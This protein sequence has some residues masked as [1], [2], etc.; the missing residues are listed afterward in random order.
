MSGVCTVRVELEL[1]G[2]WVEVSADVVAGLRWTRGL[3]GTS[4]RDRVAGTGLCE[5]ALRNDARNAGGTAGW[6]SPNHASVRTGF[7][8]G[9]AV[10]VI[11]NDGSDRPQWYGRL[12][13][14]LPDAGQFGTRQTHC[15]AQDYMGDLAEAQVRTMPAQV[16]KTEVE[17]LQAILAALPAELQPA[18]TSYDTALDSYPYA[19]YDTGGGAN[20]MDLANRVVTSTQGYLYV[21]N[22][23][24]LRYDNRHTVALRSSS[25]TFTDASL[26]APDGLSV[27]SSL[28]N[29]YNR[30]RLT[31][32][33][34]T[35]VPATVLCTLSGAQ[36]VGPG[37]TQDI[38]LDYTDPDTPHSLIGGTGFTTPIVATTD[39]L[40]NAQADGLGANLTANLSIVTSPFAATVKFAVTNTGAALV[41]VTFLQLRGTAIYDNA[42]LTAESYTAQPYG[43]R[44]L[45]IDLPYQVDANVAQDLA[46][47]LKARYLT[48]ANQV[49]AHA[50][51][52]QRTAA[53]MTHALTREIGDVVTVSETQTGIAAVELLILG[54]EMTVGQKTHL[55]C[56]YRVTPRGSGFVF[57]LD[58]A[59]R[60]V[61][62]STVAVLGYA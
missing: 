6:Y 51:D 55:T 30:V 42:P 13:S 28:E 24:T 10:R 11:A 54:I 56:R 61:L 9:I 14:I 27:P 52:P 23:G 45:D 5:F 50:F 2:V 43:D 12:R 25:V 8:F 40:G 44:P 47:Y 34:T 48:L 49:D 20:A 21:R 35:Q 39:Y 22:D 46:D 58:D 60:G 53:L 7:T 38:W 32:H 36:A 33:Q 37:E 19:F 59:V 16:T 41:Y 26:L 4:P 17:L 15:T 31:I 62:D 57:V 1:V 29:V 18:A 3:A